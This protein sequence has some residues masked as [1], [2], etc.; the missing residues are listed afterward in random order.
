VGAPEPDYFRTKPVKLGP[1]GKKLKSWHGL[2]NFFKTKTQVEEEKRE[3]ERA[4][5]SPD[6]DDTVDSVVPPEERDAD[7]IAM[8][9]ASALELNDYG[10]PGFWGGEIYVPSGRGKKKPPPKHKPEK[11]VI[12]ERVL[13][14]ETE[15]E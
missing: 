3:K 13:A 4:F 14:N 15:I 8:N 1:T 7:H 2:R 10:L 11:V 9:P 6:P 12:E 5:E